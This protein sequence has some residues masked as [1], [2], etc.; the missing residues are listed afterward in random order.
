[1]K[2]LLTVL[3]VAAL[4]SPAFAFAASD[5]VS[6]ATNTA[7]NIGGI[8]VD[9]SGATAAI[10]SITVGASSFTIGLQSGSSIKLSAPNYNRLDTNTPDDITTSTCS[11]TESSI[12]YVATAARTITIT[13][14]ASICTSSGGSGGG[15]GAATN[16]GGT[17]LTGDCNAG[18]RRGTLVACGLS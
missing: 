5:T 12:K 18:T 9:V 14:S 7:L 1:M 15:G 8:E 16:G 4:L 17:P 2:K 6:L 13:P 11:A 10:E 3:S